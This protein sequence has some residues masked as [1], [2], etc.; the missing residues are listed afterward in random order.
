MMDGQML[1]GQVCSP[2]S[3]TYDT[4]ATRN[5]WALSAMEAAGRPS[6]VLGR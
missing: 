4:W 5:E 2:E 6:P 1:Y 3:R